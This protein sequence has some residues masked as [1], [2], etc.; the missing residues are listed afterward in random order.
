MKDLS[1]I[2]RNSDEGHFI[3]V[4]ILAAGPDRGESLGKREGSLPYCRFIREVG[5]CS[6]ECD[7]FQ[8]RAVFSLFGRRSKGKLLFSGVAFPALCDF[9]LSSDNFRKFR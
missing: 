2:F 3:H 7:G 5:R 1:C 4:S 8:T 9:V 6:G